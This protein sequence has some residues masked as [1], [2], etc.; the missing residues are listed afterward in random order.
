MPATYK[1]KLWFIR[2]S[3][4]WEFI[5]SKIVD[6][7]QWI[8]YDGMMIGFHH[9]DKQGAPHAHFA[10]RLKSDGQKQKIDARM[11]TLYGVEKSQYSSKIWDGNND[12]LSYLYHDKNGEVLN[13]LGL[14]EEQC[15]DLR[16][17]NDKVQVVVEENKKRASNR[18]VDYIIE[19]TETTDR[20]E[21]ARMILEAVAD[22][23][24]YDPGDF[25]LEKY[26]NEIELKNS[27]KESKEELRRTID[28]RISR[29]PSFRR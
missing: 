3:A 20:Y 7:K 26:I 28:A 23:Q 4:P 11:K 14:S 6:I 5:K 18:I 2:V 13:E 22:G 12:A 19:S 21:I 29:L 17:V 10:L 16:R 24:F 27:K 1:S 9:G 25:Q 15:S 8:D